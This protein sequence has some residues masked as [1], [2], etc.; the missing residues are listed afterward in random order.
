MKNQT[1]EKTVADLGAAAGELLVAIEGPAA[2]LVTG[3]AY[4]SR[5]VE[6]GNLFFCIPGEVTD[7]HRFAPD[8]VKA[9]AAALCVSR[10][11]GLGV[12][13]IV[14][15][16]VRKAMPL[17]SATLLDHPADDLMLIG[18]TGTNG[19]TTTVYLIDSIFRADGRSTGLIGTVETRIAGHT[20]PGIR[21]TPE[22]LDLQELFADMRAAA[23]DAAVMEVTS[24]GIVLSRADA[25][26][27][28]VGV[29]TNLTQDHL[30]FHGDMNA[31][32]AA[33]RAFFIPERCDTAAVNV[34]DPYGAKIAAGAD[35]PLLTF[36]RTDGVD[37]RADEVDIR[38]DGSTFVART[39]KGETRIATPLVGLFQVSNCLAATAA[40]LQAGIDLD[41]IESGIRSLTA[42]PGRFET[43]SSGQ[44]FSVVV[45]YAHTPDSLD[46][47]LGA[48][49]EVAAAH[50]GR[51]VC[52]FGCGGDRDR[53]KRPL[54]GIAAARG[55]DVV[56][57]TSDNPRSEDPQA[58]MGAIL[59]GVSTVR[60]EGPDA[61][62]VDR[63]EAIGHALKAAR[64]NDVVV[65][66][67]KGHETGQTF[68]DRTVPFDDRA[69]A[70]EVLA[71]L[72][73]GE[74]GAL[75]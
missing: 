52:V 66:A 17:L 71:E 65:I 63:R 4:D 14:V 70:R 5:R 10:L 59:E 8:A 28:S 23:I 38:T 68:N 19:K 32:F 30:D 21:T 34:D 37:V 55:S 50:G 72:G 31:Y 22:S 9:G 57:V 58:I 3:A 43:I 40:A 36:G 51:V 26:S 12:P 67:G 48:A 16:D 53:S 13:E 45:D 7:G 42:V 2:A 62:I 46:N 44:P 75:P 61:S 18:V 29:F 49:R 33:K 6:P 39:P 15:S 11:L 25:V 47:V 41:A 54:M 73:W 20:L 27:F 1:K 69:V 24:H 56:I 60:P 64:P 35:V 74:P